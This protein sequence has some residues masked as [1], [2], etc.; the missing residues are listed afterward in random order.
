MTK[1]KIEELEKE[2]RQKAL[3]WNEEK[4][5]GKYNRPP[6]ANWSCYEKGY[7][8]GAEPRERRIAELEAQIEKMKNCRNCKKF[9]IEGVCGYFLQ[10]GWCKNWE[11]SK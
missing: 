1:G 8:A 5:N 9:M 7:L 10:V 11:L 4:I 2:A 3:E 6:I